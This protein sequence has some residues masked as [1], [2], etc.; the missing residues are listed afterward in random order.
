[1][2]FFDNAT[3]MADVKKAGLVLPA[4]LEVLIR[5][6]TTLIMRQQRWPIDLAAKRKKFQ[7][8]YDFMDQAGFII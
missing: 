4:A 3:K 8:R 1:M 5:M 7:R 2:T 6:R